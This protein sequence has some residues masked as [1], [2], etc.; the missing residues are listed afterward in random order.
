MRYI[1]LVNN[2]T[3]LLVALLTLDHLGIEKKHSTFIASRGTSVPRLA[4][5]QVKNLPSKRRTKFLKKEKLSDEPYHIFT[6]HDSA[7]KPVGRL[8]LNNRNCRSVSY[9]EEGGLAYEN[10][11]VTLSST[12]R[13]VGRIPVVGSI[14]THSLAKPW[15]GCQEA[16]Y[17]CLFDG[18]F[19]WVEEARRTVLENTCR[20]RKYYRHR[21]EPGAV[22]VL[23]S[24]RAE[25]MAGVLAAEDN[26]MTRHCQKVFLKP[27]P[28]LLRRPEQ[29][30]ELTGN[31]TGREK[32]YEVLG[33]T[34]ILEAEMMAGKIFVLGNHIT[35]LRRY[36]GLLGSTYLVTS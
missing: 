29:I 18:A 10:D 33:E 11:P 16:E 25:L 30:F 21:L 20:I 36:A 4:G 13:K 28:D 24:N 23:F 8:L 27:H 6:P 31:L 12:A 5:V 3:T 35:S 14:F 32:D 1:F 9:L 22:V 15:F 26:V 7:M 19:P 34:C 2:N 17:F